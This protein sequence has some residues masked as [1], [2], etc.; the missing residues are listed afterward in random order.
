MKRLEKKT[1]PPAHTSCWRRKTVTKFP[2]FRYCMSLFRFIALVSLVLN[3]FEPSTTTYNEPEAV[4][5]QHL[6]DYSLSQSAM[7]PGPNTLTHLSRA[8]AHGWHSAIDMECWMY[9]TA[10]ARKGAT[11]HL[12]RVVIFNWELMMHHR[13]LALKYCWNWGAQLLQPKTKWFRDVRQCAAALAQYARASRLCLGV[14]PCWLSDSPAVASATDTPALCRSTRW[15]L[16]L[17]FFVSPLKWIQMI[18]HGV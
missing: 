11:L 1:D 5:S 13:I 3:M 4:L 17:F 7:S 2:L 15:F 9:S 12:T 10:I 14:C 6:G 18:Y 8:D 16:I